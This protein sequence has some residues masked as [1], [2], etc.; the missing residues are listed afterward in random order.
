MH[1]DFYSFSWE[2]WSGIFGGGLSGAAEQVVESAT[3]DVGACKDLAVVERIA[4]DIVA[5]GLSY[6]GLSE[7]EQTVLDN[8]VTGFFCPE[9][10]EELLGFEYE[11]DEGIHPSCTDM[12]IDRAWADQSRPPTPRVGLLKRL[13]GHT[14][15]AVDRPSRQGKPDIELNVLP[16]FRNGRRL[17]GSGK[18][19]EPYCILSPQEV[20]QLRQ[21]IETLLDL[22]KPWPKPDLESALR[23]DFLAPVQSIESKGA[24]LAARCC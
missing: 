6:E 7:D 10:L 16:A 20:V 17:N 13:F 8:I 21:E 18:P 11:S 4:R 14:E 24:W 5:N 2:R 15:P 12:L 1:W 9:G 22:P 23:N 19:S 3:W